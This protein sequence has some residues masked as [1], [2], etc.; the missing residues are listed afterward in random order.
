MT[1]LP[2]TP[3]RP[4]SRSLARA[5]TPGAPGSA[6][7]GDALAG[8]D[9]AAPPPPP[10]S[11]WW[12]WGQ[13]AS[14][15]DV[16]NFTTQL[17]LMC[18]SG[19]DIAEAL[20]SISRRCQKPAFRAILQSVTK[21]VFSGASLATAL[22]RHVALFSESYVASVAAGESTGT[23]NDVFDR[24]TKALRT[25]QKIRGAVWSAVMYPLML[26]GVACCVVVALL[27][28]VLPQFQ[29]VFT[30]LDRDAPPLTQI[31]FDISSF[32][33]G[34]W[35][36]ILLAIGGA[37]TFLYQSRNSTFVLRWIDW[38]LLEAPLISAAIRR[39]LA[40]RLFRLLGGM[41]ETGVPLVEAIQLCTQSSG[42][43][44]FREFC[45]LLEHNVTHG[46]PL[47][48]PFLTAHFMPE[49]AGELIA[50][51]ERA[52]RVAPVMLTLAEH[53][54]EDGER[55]L[56]DTVRVLEPVII[57]GMGLLVGAVVLSIVLP[58]LDISTMAR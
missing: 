52:G 5:A 55:R 47:H 8:L 2:K 50:A 31:L 39:L 3:S 58:L 27:L 44:R 34:N 41:L 14:E 32:A 10:E 15:V 11:S 16:L 35:W 51:G 7:S 29:R 45:E 19:V 4:A 9:A 13:A 30:E 20:K 43:L 42:N 37:G 56:L 38:I 54:E 33:R 53:Y 46:R 17:S 48:G 12:P 36:I 22:R 49:E 25:E 18:R 6:P 1:A 24:L 28:F 26:T 40:G 21:D 57:I 23:L